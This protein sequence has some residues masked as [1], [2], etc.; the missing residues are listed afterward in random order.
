MSN[1]V[2][3]KVELSDDFLS[4]ILITA[5]DRSVGGS[6]YWAMPI[7]GIPTFGIDRAENVM[8]NCWRWVAVND[9]ESDGTKLLVVDHVRLTNGIQAIIDGSVRLNAEIHSCVLDS[10]LESDAGH[11]DATAADCIVQAG[12]FGE[13][14]Y[15]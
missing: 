13:V 12:M 10:V 3:V 8:N 11:I 15:G 6:W 9:G 2:A 14:L 5:F 7:E 1:A 4:D